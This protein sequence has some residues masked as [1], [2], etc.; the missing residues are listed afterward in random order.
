MSE[1]RTMH[2]RDMRKVSAQQNV[3]KVVVKVATYAFLFVMA[4]IV[5]FPFY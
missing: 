2:D 5:I 3:M 4:L 1:M